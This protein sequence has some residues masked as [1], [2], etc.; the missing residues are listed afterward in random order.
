MAKRPEL[1]FDEPTHTYTVGGLVVPSVTQALDPLMDWS[2]IQA[3]VLEHAK[4]RGTAVH[5]ATELFDLGTLDRATLSDEVAPYLNAWVTFRKD[6][7]FIPTAIE[8]RVYCHRH[9]YA[10]TIDRIGLLQG[11]EIVLD[12]KARYVLGAETGLQVASYEFAARAG[13]KKRDRYGLQL[14]PDG[15]Y[16]LRQYTEAGDMPTFLAALQLYNWRRAN[17]N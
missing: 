3:D 15:T 9:R 8:N 10:G 14:L 6:T 12:L 16:R 1:L 2:Q 11:E 5:K 7:G 17:Q 4:Q 13:G